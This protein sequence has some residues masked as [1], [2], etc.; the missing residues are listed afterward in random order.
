MLVIGMAYRESSYDKYTFDKYI[1]AKNLQGDALIS[2]DD[3]LVGGSL[4][5]GFGVGVDIHATA[6]VTKTHCSFNIVDVWNSFIS[7]LGF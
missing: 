2:L 4:G 7:W 6:S 1:F 3:G 5:A